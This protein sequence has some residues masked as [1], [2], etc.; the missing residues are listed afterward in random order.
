MH[1]VFT[2]ERMIKKMTDRCYSE[3]ITLPTLEERYRYLRI[4]GEIGIDTFGL[5]RIFNQRFYSSKEWRDVRQLVI[6]RDNGCDMALPGHDIF[7]RPMVHHINPISLV[8]LH[9]H[10]DRLFDPENLIL[11]S[12]KTHN[13][14]H[15]GSYDQIRETEYVER[16]PFDTCPWKGGNA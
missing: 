16:K 4:G 11:V 7:D 10:S 14:I 5:E 3:L 15:Y 9:N 8:D 13:A 1:Y 6:S 2:M 12:H